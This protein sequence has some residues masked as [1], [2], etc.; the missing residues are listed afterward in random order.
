MRSMLG[1]TQGKQQKQRNQ[2]REDAERLGDGEA[3]NQ[4]GKLSG[5]RR[6]I[7][8]RRGQVVAEDDADANAG[9]SH[10]EPGNPRTNEFRG[11]RVQEKAAVR[12][13]LVRSPFN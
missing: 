9:T 1:S 10:A 4:V 2:Q 11:G 13:V 8:N 12:W 6:G 3:K 7:P 5:R